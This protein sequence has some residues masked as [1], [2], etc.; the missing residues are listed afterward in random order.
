MFPLQQKQRIYIFTL[1]DVCSRWAYA[2]ASARLSAHL[3]LEFVRE[4]QQKSGFQFLCIQSDHG[5]EFTGHFT[6]F[7]QADGVRHRHTRVRQPNDNAHIERFNRTIQEEMRSEIL[8]YRSNIS[9][10]NQEI[11]KYLVYY[12]EE[13]LHMGLDYKTPSQVLRSS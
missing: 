11:R 1:I 8:R 7:V 2:R 9:L 13:R 10:L 6:T 4:A 3:L 12:N 5:P